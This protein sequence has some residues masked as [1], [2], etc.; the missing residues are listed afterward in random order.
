MTP[1]QF[2][3]PRLLVNHWTE[4]L[5][6]PLLRQKL[7]SELSTLLTPNVLKCLPPSMQLQ[8][9]DISHWIDARCVESDVLV[10]RQRQDGHL[11]GL[12]IL[13]TEL[14][15]NAVPNIHLGYLIA[16]NAWGNGYAS[17]LLDGL[18][19]ALTPGPVTRLVA[20]VGRD[21][22]A[23]TRVLQKSG[24]VLLCENAPADTE[25]YVCQTGKPTEPSAV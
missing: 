19:A 10:V 9:R 18:I 20:G 17:E 14:S 3:T 16:E 15:L 22:P 6:V 12:T 13:A 24:F 4:E 7:E 25:M 11:I 1:N 21:N 2:S 23:S 5:Q 8:D